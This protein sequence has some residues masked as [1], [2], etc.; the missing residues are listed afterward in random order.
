MLFFEF[1]LQETLGD[2]VKSVLESDEN[3]EVDPLKMTSV[4]PVMLEKN[5]RN[6]TINVETAW[7]KIVNRYGWFRII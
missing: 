3:C 4:N 1:C 2:F 7:G 5:R 6:L